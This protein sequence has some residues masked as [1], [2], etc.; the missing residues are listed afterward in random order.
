[1]NLPLIVHRDLGEAER[2][3]WQR[4]FVENN[5]TVF[6][7]IWRR[8]QD[9]AN[10]AKSGW[11]TSEDQRRRIVH[12][13]DQYGLLDG[14]GG[15]SLALTAPY[16]WLSIASPVEEIAH[17][18]DLIRDGATKGGWRPQPA[19]DGAEVL[20]R[21]DLRFELRALDNYPQ[22]VS[23]G[24]F[25][26]NSYRILDIML[27]STNTVLPDG[28]TQEPWDVFNTG[29][30]K[31]PRPGTPTLV[32]DVAQ[33]RN[34]FP[35][36][37][38]LGCGPSIEAGIPPLHDLHGTYFISDPAT[39]TFILSP[40]K[41]G[42]L[43]QL[44]EGP[45]NFFRRAS[46]PYVQAITVQP[47][48]FYFLLKELSDAGHVVGPIITNNFDGLCSAVGLTER[49]VRRYEESEIVPEVAFQ[50]GSK[51]LAVFG[52]HADRRR[53]HEA[54]RRQGLTV[55]HIDPEGFTEHGIFHPYPLESPQDG[56]IL[57][58]MTAHAFTEKLREAFPGD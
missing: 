47:T 1:M 13:Y 5:R 3:R 42:L 12:Y 6:Q 32:E 21:G 35:M 39:G 20:C 17:Y 46:I 18:R 23:A 40:S 44:L 30:R 58:R 29:F 56:D 55:V 53:V 38:E 7:S 9:Q 43:P 34:Y 28:L 25:F 24:R 27:T 49:Y 26:P 16:L 31:I 36:H 2:R 41:D 37:V 54:A 45:E 51:T 57:F 33:I 22:D 11:R 48:P 14:E 10:A 52:A 4:Q 15:Y 50:G 8:S 19:S